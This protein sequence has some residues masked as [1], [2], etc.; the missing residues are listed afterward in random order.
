MISKSTTVLIS[1]AIVSGLIVTY[2]ALN[3]YDNIDASAINLPFRGVKYGNNTEIAKVK[4][5][6]Y[7]PEE[8]YI[9]DSAYDEM[10]VMLYYLPK[11][12]SKE[13]FNEPEGKYVLAFDASTCPLNQEI[14]EQGEEYFKSYKANS[15]RGDKLQLFYINGNPAMGWEA[16]KKNSIIM[17]E[18][19]TI[20]SIG[21]MDYPAGIGMIDKDGCA[22]YSV[23]SLYLTLDEL[24]KI[25]ES[26]K[27]P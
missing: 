18:N 26:L 17:Y 15:Q 11:W 6:T 2:M 22:Y 13:K 24:K 4:L 10:E 5:P 27:Y 21:E 23:S 3:S 7:I 1:I 9:Y 20:I 19:G 16:G 12:Y 8:Y 14:I 25:M